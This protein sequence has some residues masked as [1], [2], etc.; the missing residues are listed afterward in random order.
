MWLAPMVCFEILQVPISVYVECRR[1]T[2][3][4]SAARRGKARH[5]DRHSNARKRKVKPLKASQSLSVTFPCAGHKAFSI[6]N[7]SERESRCAHW[8][9]SALRAPPSVAW[10]DAACLWH[11][12]LCEVGGILLN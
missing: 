1:G 8:N 12:H 7:N 2:E 4:S 11:R 6:K 10:C 5:V 9:L 3:R